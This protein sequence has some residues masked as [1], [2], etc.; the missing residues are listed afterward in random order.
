M[1]SAL[2]RTAVVCALLFAAHLLSA[3]TSAK[4][5]GTR[6]ATASDPFRTIVYLGAH[7]LYGGTNLFLRGDGTGVCQV[8][9]F[10]ETRRRHVETRYD[11]KLDESRLG[12]LNAL[13]EAQRFIDTELPRTSAE[14]DSLRIEIGLTLASGRSR[15]V[16]KWS[17]EVH[18]GFDAVFARL[19]ELCVE[20]SAGTPEA[21]GLPYDRR[22]RP[23][24]FSEPTS[25]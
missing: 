17:H 2:T 6:D 24:G 22:W 15:E 20:A 9:T 13:L 3:V 12:E 16:T 1:R 23:E 7:P 25:Q 21:E 10:D 14:P 4:V 19:R 5:S 8:V 18:S 11:V